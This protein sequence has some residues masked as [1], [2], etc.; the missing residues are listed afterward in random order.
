[1]RKLMALLLLAPACMA[2]NDPLPIDEVEPDEA[3]LRGAPPVAPLPPGETPVPLV[4]PVDFDG[5][6]DPE[7]QRFVLAGH[8]EAWEPVRADED[9]ARV[10]AR[11][12]AARGEPEGTAARGFVGMVTAGGHYML[13]VD[14]DAMFEAFA[15]VTTA[16][17]GDTDIEAQET[18]V[19][20]YGWSD[21]VDNRVR[22]TGTGIP[23]KVGLVAGNGQCSGA[24]IGSR[25]VRTA[26]HCLVNRS[27]AGGSLVGSARFDY[28]RD[29]ATVPASATTSTIFYGGGYLA[30]SC[31]VSS[32]TDTWSGYRANF[33]ACSWQDWAFLILPNNWWGT[34]AGVSWFGY[35]GLVSS[36]LNMEL[37]A[38]GYPACGLAESPA[39]CV[40]QG[41]Y[42]DTSAGCK[43]AA[44]TA[45]TS[46]WRVGCDISPGNSGGPA[47]REYTWY[48][49]GHCQWQD[50]TTCPSGSTNRSAPNHYLGHDDWLFNYQ[51][52]LRASYP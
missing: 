9:P 20:P 52:S 18:T 10:V 4:R 16:E 49:I 30:N 11:M 25:I 13:R 45:G 43:V 33:N 2:D 6:S 36:D 39:S 42:R 17:P 35:Q 19:V 26:A 44:F 48:L 29:G 14:D 31:G 1:M 37:Q 51:S 22:L 41:Y 38:G 21:G 15:G 23:N 47:W 7:L 8:V 34:T 28:R 50:C 32:T 3:T 24:L 5:N 27:A 46:K 40:N 12:R